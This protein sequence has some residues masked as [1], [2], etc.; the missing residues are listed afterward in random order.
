MPPNP[1]AFDLQHCVHSASRERPPRNSAYTAC[2]VC[3]V[4][5]GQATS[6]GPYGNGGRQSGGAC[7]FAQVNAALGDDAGF[8]TRNERRSA[9]QFRIGILAPRHASVDNEPEKAPC[10]RVDHNALDIAQQAVVR[11][12]RFTNRRW[13][14]PVF[15][16]DEARGIDPVH[17]TAH[18][19]QGGDRFRRRGRG[20]RVLGT[21]AQGDNAVMRHAGERIR[22]GV[23]YR[24]KDARYLLVQLVVTD[25]PVVHAQHAG[26]SGD[27]LLHTVAPDPKPDVPGQDGHPVDNLDPQ[28]AEILLRQWLQALDRATR[29]VG[30]VIVGSVDRQLVNRRGRQS[31]DDRARRNGDHGPRRHH[32]LVSQWMALEHNMLQPAIL[33]SEQCHN[34][35][36]L[37]VVISTHLGMT[38]DHARA[39]S[40]TANRRPR[41]DNP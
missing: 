39:W 12:D 20:R 33:I 34:P 27:I 13:L 15:I 11:V 26:D 8:R 9:N 22:A 37:R 30:Q 14:R 3:T 1:T 18:H 31:G 24:N 19:R 36:V 2:I 6:A 35:A 23:R 40:S 32:C 29:T 41:N 38:A 5:A 21:A 16:L 10:P 25:D 17:D 4:V 7:A 28:E